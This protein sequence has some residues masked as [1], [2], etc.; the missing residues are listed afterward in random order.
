MSSHFSANQY[1]GAFSP[2]RLQNFEVPAPTIKQWPSTRKG[3]TTVITND[4][5]HILIESERSSSSP[6]G[7]F[8]GTW[9][10]KKK[11]VQLLTRTTLQ[12]QHSNI[13]YINKG[14]TKLPGEVPTE[15][16]NEL[17]VLDSKPLT[18]NDKG[19]LPSHSPTRP[20]SPMGLS[21]TQ[22]P[23]GSR[24]LTDIS[25]VPSTNRST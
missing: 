17:A 13:E 9:Q 23:L 3:S 20:E 8:V 2:Q 10:S 12:S 11:P 14:K 19:S 24:P 5:G 25:E 4:R 7:S 6:W 18:E 22:S 15:L 21:G 1:E 16:K